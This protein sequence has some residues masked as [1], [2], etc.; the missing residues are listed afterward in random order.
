MDGINGMLG[1]VAYVFFICITFTDNV[2]LSLEYSNPLIFI[3]SSIFVFGFVNFRK[4]AIAFAGTVGSASMAYLALF[5]LLQLI[6][7]G[8]IMLKEIPLSDTSLMTF[9]PQYLLVFTI[10]AAELM[11]VVFKRISKGE[12]PLIPQKDHVYHLLTIDKQLPHVLVASFY[13]VAHL[14]IGMVL[15][16]M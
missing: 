7:G 8:K 16:L 11:Y 1:L 10:L 12:N 3:F 4:K 15:L 5:F 13:A 14:A 6:F 2:F 9:Q